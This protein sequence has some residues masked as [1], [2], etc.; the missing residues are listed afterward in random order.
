[1]KDVLCKGDDTFKPWIFGERETS[2]NY[3]WFTERGQKRYGWTT[4]TITYK[5]LRAVSWDRSSK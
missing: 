2:G 1:M 4:G 3:Q 5:I